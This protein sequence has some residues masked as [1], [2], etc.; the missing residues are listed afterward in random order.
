MK[1]VSCIRGEVFD[2]AIDIRK[3]SPTYLHYYS[4]TLTEENFKTLVIPEGFAHGFQ[5]LTQ[6][7]EMLYF[8]TKEYTPEV[9]GALNAKNPLLNIKWPLYIQ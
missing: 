8:H 3:D 5:T 6:I 9:E 1:F 2:V 7:C 4:E